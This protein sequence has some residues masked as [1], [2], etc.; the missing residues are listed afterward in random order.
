[1]TNVDF[2]NEL[3]KF[4]RVS[5]AHLPTP[6]EELT[7]LTHFFGGPDIL[8][9]RD[10]CTGLA[11]GGNK[12]RKLEFLIA[13]AQD[14]GFDTIVTGGAIQSN[15]CRQTIAAATKNGL[16]CILVLTPSW[17]KGQNG[18]LLL[19]KILGA[20]IVLTNEGQPWE[21]KYAEIEQELLGQGK[22]PYVIPTGGSNALG[23][24]GY[25]E[26]INELLAQCQQINRQVNYIVSASGSGGT[27]AGMVAGNKLNGSPLEVIGVSVGRKKEDSVARISSV[28]EE[29]GTLLSQS[30]VLNEHDVEVLDAYKGDGYG[31]PTEAGL[32]EIQRVARLEGIILDP[33]YT[34]KA[35]A[36]LADLVKNGRFSKSD[37]VVF[38]H[39]GGTP[40]LFPYGYQR[41]ISKS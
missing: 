13:D 4:R 36:A 22:N 38:L 8:I 35:M 30:I 23:S 17:M 24:L 29:V 28:A 31:V 11:M 10:D 16:K 27:Q 1:M 12:A 39:T 26:M 33:I 18:N 6:L 34:A 15:H 37:T 2:K 19:D 9:K 3:A 7:Q 41:W 21:D 32:D 40:A 5:L 20:E 14:R 25:V